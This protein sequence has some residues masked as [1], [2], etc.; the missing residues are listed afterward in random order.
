MAVAL[1]IETFQGQLAGNMAS[2]F[3]DNA[4]VMA[5]FVKGSSR[6]AEQNIIIGESWMEF[7]RNQMAVQFWRVASKANCADGPSRHDFDLMLEIGAQF[8]PPE[9]P[10]YLWTLW[11]VAPGPQ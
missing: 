3:I 1:A 2:F 7:A 10:A 5:G 11:D 8:V 9:L 4:G 6:S